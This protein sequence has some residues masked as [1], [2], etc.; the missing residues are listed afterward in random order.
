[1]LFAHGAGAGTSHP[2]MQ[3]WARRLGGLGA[4]HLLDYPYMREGRRFPDRL[5]KLLAAHAAALAGLRAAHSGP[6]VLIG[7]SMGARVGCHLSVAAPVDAVVCL[8]YPLVGGGKKR[9]VRDEVLK[10][11]TTPALFVQGTRDPMGPLDR[12]AEVRRDM[13][14]PSTLH[15]VEGGDHG[16]EV[17]KRALAR[18]GEDQDEVDDRALHAIRAFLQGVGVSS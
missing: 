16:L 7:K 13:T 14:A 15:I 18:A 3:R 5:P 2:W 4:V 10:A 6:V 1:M 11:M 8:G 17:G 12:F 9:P